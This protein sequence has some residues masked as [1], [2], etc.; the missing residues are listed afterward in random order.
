MGIEFK[1]SSLL[2]GPKVHAVVKKGMVFNIN[3]GLANL[4]NSEATDKEGK[5]YA[6]FIDDMVIVNEEQP[7]TNLTLSKK[8][9]KNISIHRK[10]KLKNNYIQLCNDTLCI[11]GVSAH[12]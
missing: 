2:L 8:K 1:E 5:T 7:A 3:V 11:Q 4:I 10:H 12:V 9:V 6:L